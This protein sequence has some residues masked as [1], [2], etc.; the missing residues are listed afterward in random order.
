MKHCY[1]IQS[2]N[3]KITFANATTQL[4]TGF[5]GGLYAYNNKCI[6]LYGIHS[7]PLSFAIPCS[8]SVAIW[9]LNRNTDGSA[10]SSTSPQN[11][12]ETNTSPALYYWIGDWNGAVS[13]VKVSSNECTSCIPPEYSTSIRS[14]ICKHA[15]DSISVIAKV[16]TPSSYFRIT[17]IYEVG[18]LPN[19][20]SQANNGDNA[21]LLLVQYSK[22]LYL[23]GAQVLNWITSDTILSIQKI[24]ITEYFV[25]TEHSIT[26]LE[27]TANLTLAATS[28]MSIYKKYNN[29]ETLTALYPI[30]N[31]RYLYGSIGG[32]IGYLTL[33]DDNDHSLDQ[34]IK[35]STTR[36]SCI[37]QS[38]HNP[39]LFII[40][41]PTDLYILDTTSKS[42]LYT[43]H[44][45][46]RNDLS[47]ILSS[48]TNNP[49]EYILGTVNGN[50]HLITLKSSYTPLNTNI[51]NTTTTS[52][53][54]NT[55]KPDTKP[56]TN[57]AKTTNDIYDDLLKS[58]EL[59][60]I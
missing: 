43:E 13:L 17:Y 9:H 30:S 29:T 2:L 40:C 12:T 27:I 50:I 21:P 41:T 19:G 57:K 25:I 60:L 5:D 52:I 59:G 56:D 51:T 20:Y 6:R 55:T 35:I 32:W 22:Q 10:T 23:I 31:N 33:S 38:T 7:L 47:F 44:I 28:T 45:S 34:I 39:S 18:H 42:V 8:D 1:F 54:T 48:V 14:I 3:E 11:I 26:K 24:S 58:I 16:F 36:I 4:I 37:H 46:S 53:I 49:L 15:T